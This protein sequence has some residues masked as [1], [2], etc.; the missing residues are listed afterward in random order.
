M[1]ASAQNERVKL[2]HALLTQAKTRRRERKIA[3]EGVRLIDDAIERGRTPDFILYDAAAID[4]TRLA[5]WQARVRP[6]RLLSITPDLSKH[7]STTEQPQGAV[8]VFPLP[9]PDLP[10][11]PRRVLILD[12]IRDPGNLGTILR[13]A[14]AA[15]VQVVIL[16]PD[17]VDPYNPKVLRAGM[18][19]HFRVPIVEA[20][21]HESAPY[22]DGLAIYRAAS[23]GDADYT[24]VDWA[25]WA[26]IIGSEAH[27]ASDQAQ[28]IA[29]QR[30][31]I[32]M[33]AATESINAAAAAAVL[34]FEA[35]RQRTQHRSG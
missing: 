27:G 19:A 15:G 31:R 16:S 14:A 22:C 28:A 3:L 6:E 5:A 25:A 1:I 11:Q 10:R 23:S 20:P 7:L 8:A 2:A 29:T 21:W 4:Y 24:G 18:G 35:A 12:A 34:L 13:T 32:P 26:L 17:C 9:V 30:I 33:A